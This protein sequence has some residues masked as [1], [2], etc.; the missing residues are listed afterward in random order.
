VIEYIKM[1]RTKIADARTGNKLERG[2][3]LDAAANFHAR[4]FQGDHICVGG[5]ASLSVGALRFAYVDHQL[6]TMDAALAVLEALDL[7]R[8]EL[9]ELKPPYRPLVVCFKGPR[10]LNAEEGHEL[11]WATL[12]AMN[13]A[14]RGAYPAT[15]DIS[16]DPEDQDF[17][18]S[19]RKRAWFVNAG[20]PNHPRKSRDYPTPMWIINPQENFDLLRRADVF[21]AIK[22]A[23]AKREME[24]QGSTNPL[25]VDQGGAHQWQQVTSVE[26]QSAPKCPF[27]HAPADKLPGPGSD[28]KKAS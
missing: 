25:L 1:D 26:G 9:P 6:G 7:F 4:I 24:Y 28:L 16:E 22:A 11:T 23:N 17:G 15:E 8:R 10:S 5:Q 2:P 19:W 13:V 18:F 21:G 20:F 14:D 12:N 27:H 3:A